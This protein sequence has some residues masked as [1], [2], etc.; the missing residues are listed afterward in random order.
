[1]DADD[2]TR[3]DPEHG[4]VFDVTRRGYDRHQVDEQVEI[5]L[6]R[7]AELERLL[8]EQRELAEFAEAQVTWL[9]TLVGDRPSAAGSAAAKDE[10]TGRFRAPR[11]LQSSEAV[12]DPGQPSEPFGDRVERLLRSA[13]REAADLRAMAAREA[14]ATIGRAQRDAQA[15]VS[16]GGHVPPLPARAC[17]PDAENHDSLSVARGEELVWLRPLVPREPGPRPRAG[18]DRPEDPPPEA[19]AVM[20]ARVDLRELLR[21]QERHARRLHE[22]QDEVRRE[23]HQLLAITTGV[24]NCAG[25]RPS[26][27]REEATDKPGREPQQVLDGTIEPDGAGAR[28]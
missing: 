4:P 21:C 26:K 2:G 15:G 5:L 1:M 24:L 14:A 20:A 16:G 17:N 19:E 10:P 27:A 7:V 3:L 18:Q 6:D 13:E 25:Q 28:G 12:A 8:R 22:L 11:D 23:F 9:S